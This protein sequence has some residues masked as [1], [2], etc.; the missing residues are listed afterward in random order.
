MFNVFITIQ[1]KH[2]LQFV[3]PVI[4]G[5]VDDLLVKILPSVP[6]SVFKIVQAGNH[7]LLQTPPCSIV[8][9]VQIGVLG[10]I[11]MV[12]LILTEHFSSYVND[13][14]V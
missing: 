3:T 12:K 6:H 9:R 2:R 13:S 7:I 4:N 1:S 5:F 11:K 8:N 10:A 14:I